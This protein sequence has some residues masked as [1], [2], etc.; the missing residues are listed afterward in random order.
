M[1]FFDD[2]IVVAKDIIKFINN[3]EWTRKQFS[4]LQAGVRYILHIVF[5][6]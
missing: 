2:E 3:H 6:L 5:I 4:K 1:T